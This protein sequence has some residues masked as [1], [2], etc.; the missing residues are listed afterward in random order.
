MQKTPR[1]IL[2]LFLTYFWIIFEFSDWLLTLNVNKI[3]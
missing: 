1:E 2:Q 3:Y